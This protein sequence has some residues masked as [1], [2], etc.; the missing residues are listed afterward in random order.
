MENEIKICTGACLA[1]RTFVKHVADEDVAADGHIFE[2]G[3]VC[4]PLVDHAEAILREVIR[5]LNEMHI[6]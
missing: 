4:G 2:Q 3:Q 6:R 5:H 1:G